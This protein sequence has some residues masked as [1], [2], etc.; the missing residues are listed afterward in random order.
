MKRVHWFMG[1]GLGLAATGCIGSGTGIPSTGEETASVRISSRFTID[2]PSG[3]EW[4]S[5]LID[6]DAMRPGL[7]VRVE[8]HEFYSVNRVWADVG[9]EPWERHAI[10]TTGEESPR[11][12]TRQLATSNMG[13]FRD[14]NGAFVLN[15]Q[16]HLIGESTGGS[17]RSNQRRNPKAAVFGVRFNGARGADQIRA[18]ANI[19]PIDDPVNGR[20]LVDIP[21]NEGFSVERDQD[22][23]RPGNQANVW[24]DQVSFNTRWSTGE[25]HA[26]Y[27]FVTTGSE[28]VD[29]RSA[30]LG[31]STPDAFRD[32]RGAFALNGQAYVLGE[33]TGGAQGSNAVNPARALLNIVWDGAANGN[34]AVSTATSVTTL[35]NAI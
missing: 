35:P 32:T 15:G 13:E 27:N 29:G 19:V 21:A 8:V 11:G 9:G 14:V 28:R 33:R 5:N 34:N 6:Q 3:D 30:M 23:S 18:E 17:I 26:C 24:I 1:I 31:G 7:Q 25:A 2:I 12:T 22:S 20:L 16:I 10:V 4:A